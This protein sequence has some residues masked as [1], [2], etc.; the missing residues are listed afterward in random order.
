MKKNIYLFLLLFLLTSCYKL[1]RITYDLAP[2]SLLNKVYPNI[3][4]ESYISTNDSAKLYISFP[5]EHFDSIKV[6][7]LIPVMNKKDTMNLVNWNYNRIF[8]RY[9]YEF[10]NSESIFN[11]NG[12]DL[13]IDCIFYNKDQSRRYTDT[14]YLLENDRIYKNRL[15]YIVPKLH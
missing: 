1:Q 15:D 8:K 11:S 3:F 7:N 12:V 2:Q 13:I 9:T 4:I 5:L 6:I 14:V 10:Y